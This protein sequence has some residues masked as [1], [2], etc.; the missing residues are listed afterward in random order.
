M[1]ERL[2]STRTLSD[3]VVHD[4][5]GLPVRLGTVWADKPAVIVFVRHFG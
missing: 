5:D 2:A 1:S 4:L 3:T